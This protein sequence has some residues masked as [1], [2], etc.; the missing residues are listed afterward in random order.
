MIHVFSAFVLFFGLSL[1]A[2][3]TAHGSEIDQPLDPTAPVATVSVIPQGEQQPS[4]VEVRLEPPDANAGGELF[5]SLSRGRRHERRVLRQTEPGTYRL[6]Y[7]FPER[8]VW[9]VYLRFGAGQAGSVAWA[10]LPVSVDGERAGDVS[11]R[12]RN[13]FARAVPRYV[14]PLGYAVFGVLASLAVV[15]VA[16]LLHRI[17]HASEA[18]PSPPVASL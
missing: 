15:G 4:A 18:Y 8:G 2:Y 6:L 16:Y 7:A 13:G 3:V 12:F 5:L 11:V 9:N 10:N 14:Q 1:T 17:R